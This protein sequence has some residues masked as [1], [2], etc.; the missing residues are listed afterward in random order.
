MFLAAS[1]AICILSSCAN[2]TAR[3]S[4]DN[5]D[6]TS[7]SSLQNLSTSK[8]PTADNIN[9]IRLQALQQTALEVGAQGGLAKQSNDINHDLVAKARQ[10]DQ[11]FNF[12][13]MILHNNV[14]PPVLVEG[15][16]LL[17]QSA[18]DTLRIADHTYKIVKQARFYYSS[19]NVAHLFMDGLQKA[20]STRS[21][22]N[23]TNCT[24][25]KSMETLCYPRLATRYRTS[26][27]YL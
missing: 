10:L 14:L 11:T 24:R 19:S 5:V 6:T 16:T 23:P 7:L 17:D 21:D 2:Q 8:L 26:K 15:R 1:T 13:P 22:A 18:P 3:L 20:G 25:R 27:Y 12:H 4:T 9:K